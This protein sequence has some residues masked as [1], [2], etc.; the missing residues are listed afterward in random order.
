MKS[1]RS[2]RGAALVEAAVVLPV[3]LGFLAIMTMIR[4]VYVEKIDGATK[5]R[6]DVL[7]F[8]GNG[9]EGKFGKAAKVP[10]LSGALPGSSLTE[11]HTK[12]AAGSSSGTRDATSGVM[13]KAM[14]TIEARSVS[15]QTGPKWTATVSG[16]A[17]FLLCNEKAQGS[18]MTGLA[19][20][21]TS[22]VAGFLVP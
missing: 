1:R 17:S 16:H 5:T 4:A 14:A 22:T 15:T 21:I 19:G 10:V 12:K 9:C 6:S 3:L 2:Q 18:G 11:K 13:Q 8:A 20:W 7:S